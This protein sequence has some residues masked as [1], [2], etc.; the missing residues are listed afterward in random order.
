MKKINICYVSDEALET[1]KNNLGVAYEKITKKPNDS[2][3]LN[4]FLPPEP[5]VTKKYKI[6]D[7]SLNLSENG[8]YKDVEYSNSI[9]LYEHLKLLPR[10][11]LTDERFWL[12]LHFKFYDVTVKAMEINSPTTLENHWTFSQGRRRGIFF[13]VLSRS[14]FRVE[15]SVDETLED[16]Y[17][18]T[19]YI[20]EKPERFRTLS[21]RAYSNKKELVLGALKAQK[22]FEEKYPNKIEN[23]HY[24]LISK[25]I[26]RFGSV[27]LL[28]NLLE[29]D[30]YELVFETLIKLTGVKEE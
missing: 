12:W 16:K 4:D 18:L 3:W 2:T 1:F 29:D 19:K 20:I 14:F 28:D 15:R 8:T 10:R 23:K 21:W 17:E 6:N 25:R 26:S 22:D 11:V 24:N 27:N 30:V 9:I 7:F 5:Y 13:G